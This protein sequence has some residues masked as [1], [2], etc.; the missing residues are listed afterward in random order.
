MVKE[1]VNKSELFRSLLDAHIA[2][3]DTTGEKL[4]MLKNRRDVIQKDLDGVDTEIEIATEALYDKEVLMVREALGKIRVYM[5]PT[6]SEDDICKKVI[7][8]IS[9]KVLTEAEIRRI[10]IANL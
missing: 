9:A 2:K 7:S 8:R 10:V 3:A 1:G 5:D 6:E 4:K